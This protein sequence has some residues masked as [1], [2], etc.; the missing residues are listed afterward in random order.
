MSAQEIP[1][2]WR[3]AGTLVVAAAMAFPLG[4]YARTAR[5]GPV[6]VLAPLPAVW[7]V[8]AI[9]PMLGPSVS[10]AA[11]GLAGFAAGWA[12]RRRTINPQLL[13]ASRL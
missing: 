7:G 2:F 1:A 9:V 10:E 13:S 4:Y 12:L 11:F 8:V 6:W 3:W 5:F